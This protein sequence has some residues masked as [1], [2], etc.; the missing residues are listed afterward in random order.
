MTTKIDNSAIAEYYDKTQILYDIFWSKDALHYG[1]WKDGTKT[2]SEAHNN[3]NQ[4]VCE[5]LDV[6]NND[7]V[8]DAGCGVGGT[9]LYIA[10]RFGV[11]VVG[12]TL[13]EVQM[14]I[15]IKKT[16]EDKMENL[17]KFLK[18][19]FAKTSFEDNSF[20]KVF[21][22]ESVCH[23]ESKYD[24]LK[25]AYRLLTDG[26]K[27]V[28]VDAFLIRNDF[29]EAEKKCYHEFLNGMALPNLETKNDFQYYMKKAG[30]KNI[31]FCDKTNEVRKI[32]NRMYFIGVAFY[33]LFWS[34]SALRLIPQKMYEH[35]L[36][37]LVQKQLVDRRMVCYGTFVAEK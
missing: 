9:S 12:I 25:E 35:N 34:L 21:G 27:I 3:T 2:L 10:K 31:I 29:N 5:C 16:S 20:T 22:I 7:C 15:A 26:G 1:L 8:L 14:K 6:N 33:P 24:F 4:L 30:F 37:C 18:E 23:A 32:S 17:V 11:K 28:V 13:S 36:S 19:D